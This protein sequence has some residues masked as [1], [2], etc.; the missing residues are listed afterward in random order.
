M[1]G[2]LHGSLGFVDKDFEVGSKQHVDFTGLRL[3]GSLIEGRWVGLRWAVG[4]VV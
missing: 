2:G 1:W 4:W 3:C